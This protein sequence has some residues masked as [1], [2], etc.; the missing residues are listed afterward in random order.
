MPSGWVT[1]RPHVPGSSACGDERT[2]M[3]IEK[4]RTADGTVY[5]VRDL[6][7]VR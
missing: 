2:L 3:V 6:G 4:L 1:V 5:N 7:E